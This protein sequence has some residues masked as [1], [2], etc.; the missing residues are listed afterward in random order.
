MKKLIY[1]T[2]LAIALGS[3]VTSCRSHLCAAY[4][5]NHK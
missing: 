4:G 3:T 1:I 5:A 2:I